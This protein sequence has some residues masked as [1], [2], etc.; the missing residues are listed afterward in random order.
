[1]NNTR[2]E[3]KKKKKK[4]KKN[5]EDHIKH[6]DDILKKLNDNGFCIPRDKIELEKTRV[7]WLSY[8][9]SE[10]DIHPDNKKYTNS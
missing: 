7:K 6:V 8:D 4:K 2:L 10:E 1:M 9:I 3:K 5:S